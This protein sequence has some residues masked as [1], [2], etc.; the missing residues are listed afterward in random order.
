MDGYRESEEITP[1]D[2]GRT[3]ARYGLVVMYI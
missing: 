3:L 1:T 2:C